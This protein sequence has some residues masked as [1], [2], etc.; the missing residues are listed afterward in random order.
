M[1]YT[2]LFFTQVKFCHMT[3]ARLSNAITATCLVCHGNECLT[4]DALFAP[5]D[6]SQQAA[7]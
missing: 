2:W 6:T 5:S 3:F 1:P 7:A 4:V